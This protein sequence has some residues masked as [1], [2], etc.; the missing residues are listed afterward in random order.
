MRRYVALDSLRGLAAL[1]VVLFHIGNFGAIANLP[2]FRHGWLMV[3][4]FFVLSGFVIAA[5]YG[6]RLAHGFSRAGFML[7]RL[8]RV[9]PLHLAVVAVMAVA[10]FLLFRPWLNERHEIVLL[11]QGGLL[12]D[13]LS[14]GAGNFY[15]PVSWSIS[16][17]IM[18]YYAAAVLLPLGR[19]GLAVAAVTIALS[20][21]ALATGWNH[22][23][24]GVLL[25]RGVLGFALGMTCYALHHRIRIELHAWMLTILEM[26]VVGAV[27]WR[28]QD[29]VPSGVSMLSAD[30]LF[31]LVVFVF[32][33]DGG[34][35]SR[36]LQTRVPKALGRLSYSIYMIHVPVLMA[37]DGLLPVIAARLVPSASPR[38]LFGPGTF[39]GTVFTLSEV[40]T[41]VGLSL[42]TFRWMEEPARKWSRDRVARRMSVKEVRSSASEGLSLA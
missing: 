20:I 6:E 16:V 21:A 42:L 34:A 36:L 38:A 12:L 30:P 26:A 25:Q 19:K 14:T 32:A 5:S 35:V 37:L 22:F 40:A 10:E 24:F 4:F 18:L 23:G 11:V 41:V 33:K 31:A 17:E 29:P 9:V 8:G 39:W 3:D 28:L 27:I 1:C 13:G 15:A 2:P 7:L